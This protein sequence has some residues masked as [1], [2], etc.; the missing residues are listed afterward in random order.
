MNHHAVT[1]VLLD[2]FGT[3]VE[4]S[5]SR[6]EQGYHGSHA[7]VRAMGAD[8]G[9]PEF[10]TAWAAESARFDARSDA[11]DSEFSMEEVAT[12]FLARLLHRDPSAT[13][14]GDLIDTY[15]GEWNTG[16]SYPAA[17]SQIVEVLASRYRLAVVT[18]THH[19]EL[20]PD[21]LAAMGIASQFEVV[22]TSV[23]TGWRKPH[24]AIY[25][26]TLHRLG[27]DA[28]S[29]VFVGDSFIADFAGPEAVGITAFLIDPA[30]ESNVPEG[31]RLCSLAD[32][33][34]RLGLHSTHR[35]DPL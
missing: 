14:I 12:P 24:P 5:P 35:Q 33:P 22:V 21:H 1:H 27:A 17:T 3:L 7:L 9:Y 4:Y 32:L 16:V 20:V 26:E 11:D 15:L 30:K 31:R 29:S 6:T 28:A 2:F 10:L 13:E 25:A 19:A 34:G 18:N 8:V 23:E